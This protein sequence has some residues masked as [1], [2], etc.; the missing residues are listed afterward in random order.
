MLKHAW[1][2]DNAV[3]AC[4]S[5]YATVSLACSLSACNVLA[6]VQRSVKMALSLSEND[7]ADVCAAMYAVAD[8]NA[9]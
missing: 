8:T 7:L 3:L 2:S 5:L 1:R 6:V 9:H 4:T